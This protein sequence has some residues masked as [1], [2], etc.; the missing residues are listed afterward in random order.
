MLYEIRNAWYDPETFEEYITWMR[1]VA[2]AFYRSKA[3][4][5]G[6]WAMN[7]MPPIIRGSQTHEYEMVPANFTWIVRWKDREH[8]DKVWNEVR[9]SEEYQRF[10][11]TRPGGMQRFFRIEIK[12]AEGL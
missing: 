5:V 11:S 8:R 6:F 10:S 12:F 9:R 1:E 4:I 2:A 3:D 7:D